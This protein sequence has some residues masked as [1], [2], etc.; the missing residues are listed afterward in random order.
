MASSNAPLDTQ[1]SAEGELFVSGL[2]HGRER[3][4]AH[5]IEHGLDIKQRTTDD[6]VRHFPPDAIM[7]GLSERPS[8]RAAILAECTG[9]KHRI[10]LKK[11]AESAGEDL[12]IALNEK[13]TTTADIV[14]LFRPD[15]RVRYLSHQ[16]LWH[17]AVEGEFWESGKKAR[18]DVERARLYIAYMLDRALIDELLTHR[19][20]VEGIGVSEIAKL[21]PRD[22][23]EGIIRTALEH[24]HGGKPFNEVDLMRCSPAHTLVEHIP[25]RIIWNQVV[26]PKLAEAHGFVP[27]P[28]ED[29]KTGRTIQKPGRSAS[30]AEDFPEDRTNPGAFVDEFAGIIH[31]ASDQKH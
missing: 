25:L 19:D 24:S 29:E 14:R 15:D 30:G 13:E 5:V 27:D 2:S 6:F 17:Y 8:L 12:Q 26:V 9:I 3:F 22:E 21:M 20:I 7:N 11:T 31:K 10:A 18:A 4:I 23:L 1:E 28:I 16:A